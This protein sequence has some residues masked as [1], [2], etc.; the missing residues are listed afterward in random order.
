MTIAEQLANILK[1]A[2][3]T[4]VNRPSRKTNVAFQSSVAAAASPAK[5]KYAYGPAPTCKGNPGETH[6]AR[7]EAIEALIP[8]IST[9]AYIFTVG[10]NA[11]NKHEKHL[12]LIINDPWTWIELPAGKKQAIGPMNPDQVRAKLAE[13]GYGFSP[14]NA[15]W[16]TDSRGNPTRRR[17]HY[18]AQKVGAAFLNEDN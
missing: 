4:G 6:K 14:S 1:E 7:V 13:G 3:K 12:N 16:A 5:G 17:A 10:K 15:L 11:K 2:A 18:Q 9:E 8:G